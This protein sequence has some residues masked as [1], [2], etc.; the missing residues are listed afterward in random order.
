[1]HTIEL[2]E[3]GIIPVYIFDGKPP[4]AKK[5]TLD[6]RT[7]NRTKMKDRVDELVALRDKLVVENPDLTEQAADFIDDNESNVSSEEGEN[8]NV[9]KEIKKLNKKIEKIEKNILVVKRHHSLEVMEL[10]EALGIPY[11]QAISESE[12]TC[13]YLQKKG[14]VDYVVTEDTDS[15]TFGATQVIF[16]NEL[17]SLDKVLEGMELSFDSFIDFCI[18]CGCDYTSTI[19]KVGPVNAYKLIKNHSSIDSFP[20]VIPDSFDYQTARSL[21]KQNESYNYEIKPFKIKDIDISKTEKLIEKYQLGDYY[22]NKIK[23]LLIGNKQSV[24][25]FTE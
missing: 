12:E 9:V 4:D 23:M 24:C 2:L 14:F 6:K 18:L 16:G 11:L 7:D 1:M 17:Y 5:N 15:L 13:A 8:V 21:F 22:F 3:S 25:Y 19:P 20:I 10:L